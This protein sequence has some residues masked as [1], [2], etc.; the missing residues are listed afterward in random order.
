[1]KIKKE[2]LCVSSKAG[3]VAPLIQKELTQNKEALTKGEFMEAIKVVVNELMLLK[4]KEY[5]G[6]LRPRP[7]DPWEPT[8]AHGE[9][10]LFLENLDTYLGMDRHTKDD[11]KV[12]VAETFLKGVALIMWGQ[13]KAN[14]Q[15]ENTDPTYEEFKS[16]LLTH[17]S[18]AHI[19][20]E[21]V[22]HMLQLREKGAHSPHLRFVA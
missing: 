21:A 10:H 9:G 20:D 4:V 7:L 15:K 2:P 11:T 8:K 16:V 1:M 17:Y 14:L 19:S 12:K 3:L 6:S 22:S 13:H 18:E 5:G